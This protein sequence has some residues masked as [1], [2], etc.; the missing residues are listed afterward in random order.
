MKC[1]INSCDSSPWGKVPESAGGTGAQLYC[2]S[3]L[4]VTRA[5]RP[6]SMCAGQIGLRTPSAGQEAPELTFLMQASPA[7]CSSLLVELRALK[8]AAMIFSLD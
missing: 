5:E 3:R 6:R 8:R 1:T 2:V 4:S 7:S